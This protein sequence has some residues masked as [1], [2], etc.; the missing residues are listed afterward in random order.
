MSDPSTPV[1]WGIELAKLWRCA[2][3]GFPVDVKLLALDYTSKKFSDPIGEIIDHAPHG[4]DGI[5]GMLVRRKKR[6]DWCISYDGN[7]TIPGRVNFTLAHELGHY[8]LHRTSRDDFRCGQEQ[9]MD[10]ESVESKRIENQ[11]NVF[12]S[13]LLM[14]RTDFEEQIQGQQITFDLLGDCAARYG[15]SLTATALKWLEFTEDAAMLI[16][17][18]A[19]D[20]I[21]WSYC[22]QAAKRIHCY[23][24][25]GEELPDAVKTS[26]RDGKLIHGLTRRVAPGVWHATAEAIESL[27]I[28]DQFEQ[29]IFLVKFPYASSRDYEKDD[30][31][32]AFDVLSERA[33]GFNWTK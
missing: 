32:D 19:D 7:I 26:L 2:G 28:S 3:L 30:E 18:D 20:F 4:L 13:Y 31:V 33:K 16:V 9:M 14:P 11:A 8:L 21:H 17:A 22:S 5:D 15:T 10:Y 24:A 25:P 23:R 12:A 1:R 6:G 29:R 27:V